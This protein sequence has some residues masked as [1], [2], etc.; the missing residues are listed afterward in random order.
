MFVVGQWGNAVASRVWDSI[1][2]DVVLLERFL[3][4]SRKWEIE[5]W[6][7]L[8]VRFIV[9]DSRIKVYFL[10]QES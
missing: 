8:E 7:R 1:Y 6:E 10:I 3:C 4:L 2:Q 9:V 5:G